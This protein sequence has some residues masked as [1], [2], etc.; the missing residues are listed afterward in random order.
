MSILTERTIVLAKVETTYGTD[1][2]PDPSSD[3]IC[4]GDL[5]V[6]PNVTYNNPAC[7]DGILSPRQGVAGGRYLE[8]TFTH[9]LQ[10]AEGGG[11]TPPPAS[12]LLKACGFAETIDTTTGN[13][14]VSYNPVSTGFASVTLYVYYDGILWKITGARG[15]VE[16]AA[17]AGETVKLNFTF[18]GLWNDA[19]DASFPTSVTDGGTNPLVAMGGAL[20]WGSYNPIIES[21]S[22]N[23][24]NSL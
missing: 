11:A 24:N 5:R 12:P 2:S 3:F 15:N 7:M 18:Q 1:A 21:L 4:V 8:V 19:E 13:E 22:V 9:E 23:M 16:V 6:N 17:T 10:A 14:N 20:T